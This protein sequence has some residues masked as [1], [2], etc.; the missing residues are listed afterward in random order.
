M[1]ESLQGIDP[2]IVFQ[3]VHVELTPALQAT[4][5]GKFGA[6]LDHSDQI[7]RIVVHLE[8]TAS[9]GKQHVFTA[10]GRIEIRGP[11]L[12]AREE[13]TD[14]YGVLEAV[15]A[16]LDHQLEKRH[17]KKKVKRNHPHTADVGGELPKVG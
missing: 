14:A 3:G 17:G 11:D 13:G 16:K 9:H 15:A 10:T 12:S 8:K 6:L 7:V 1:N 5:Y 2:R 4:I